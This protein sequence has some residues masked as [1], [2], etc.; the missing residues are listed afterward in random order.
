MDAHNIRSRT[1]ITV[2]S[3]TLAPD[4]LPTH[5]PDQYNLVLSS[6][7]LCML[8]LFKMSIP[9]FIV[10]LTLGLNSTAQSTSHNNILIK[11]AIVMT[12]THGNIQGGSIYIKDGKIAAV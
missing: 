7:R 5:M 12:V 1:S 3:S 11:N 9:G 8:R 4:R 6:R 2:T 10:L